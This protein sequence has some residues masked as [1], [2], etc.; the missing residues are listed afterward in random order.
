VAKLD[1]CVG[2][3]KV[4]RARLTKLF[5]VYR[6]FFELFDS[7]NSQSVEESVDW[8]VASVVP[9]V[10]KCVWSLQRARTQFAFSES[11]FLSLNK[12]NL[13]D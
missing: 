4:E 5:E 1:L 12:P 6:N 10:K 3:V 2:F 8:L 11:L 7:Q 9:P 13:P